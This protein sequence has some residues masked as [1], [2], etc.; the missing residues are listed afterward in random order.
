MAYLQGS[1]N[2]CLILTFLKSGLDMLNPKQMMR[3]ILMILIMVSTSLLYGC[4]TN[5][6]KSSIYD[7]NDKILQDG[8]SFSFTDRIG[9]TDENR[10]DI[11]YNR[12]YGVQTI[13]VIKVE[14]PGVINVDYAS[15]VTSGDFKVVLETPEQELIRI[16]EDKGKRQG[17]HK[18]NATAGTYK[19]KIVG[20]NAFGRIKVDLETESEVEIIV[21]DNNS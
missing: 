11:R 6:Q 4:N 16:V 21:Q 10:L 15:E 17:S 9:K 14:K 1:D 18:L 8:D 7:N 5:E 2:E 12:F 3:V 13:W 19:I 20:K